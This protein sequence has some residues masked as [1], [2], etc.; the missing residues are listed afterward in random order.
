VIGPV[1]DTL[2]NTGLLHNIGA[3]H[4]VMRVQDALDHFDSVEKPDQTYPFQTNIISR[5]SI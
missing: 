2:S 5:K 4:I 3:N 1:R